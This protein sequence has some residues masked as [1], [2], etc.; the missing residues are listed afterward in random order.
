MKKKVIV[1]TCGCYDLFHVG[2]LQ[3][4]VEAKKLGNYVIVGISSDSVIKKAKGYGRP[5]IPQKQRV[6]IISEIGAVDEVIIGK[7]KDFVDFIL[8]R[9]PDIY[10][11][12]GDYNIN[13]INQDERKAIESYDGKIMFTKH[14]R[15]TSTT[16]I[17]EEVRK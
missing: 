16:N 11:K 4:I 17:I 9:K 13:K 3:T 6:K 2:H 10:L 5:I 8:D 12:G 7:N 14:I 15:K 1:F